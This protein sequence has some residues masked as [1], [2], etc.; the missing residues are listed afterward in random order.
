MN[1]DLDYHL[2]ELEVARSSRDPRRA[3]PVIP[4]G[5]T[6]VLDV[7]CGAGQTLL[8]CDLKGARA[9]GIEYDHEP[10][11]LGKQMARHCEF[12]QGTG[13][14]LPFA[15]GTFDFVFSRVALPYMRV[16][17]AVAEIAR[18]LKPGGALWFTLHP[19]GMFSWR[20]RFGGP[21]QAAFEIYRLANSALLHVGAG[22]IRYPLN[23]ART[24]SYQTE[25]GMRRVLDRCGLEAVRVSRGAHFV[26]EARKR[27]RQTHT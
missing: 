17:V 4:E 27:G 11:R 13:E 9:F 5:C 12:V 10:A 3:L 1:S 16:S 7:G 21:K 6:R 19:M 8:A 26:V 25:P 18:V 23:R 20:Q 2:R 14:T 24:E 22:Q 15:D